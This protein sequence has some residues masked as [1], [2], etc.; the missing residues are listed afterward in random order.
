MHPWSRPTPRPDFAA[1]SAKALKDFRAA[2]AG[3]TAA[4][5]GAFKGREIWNMSW[6]KGKHKRKLA[7][8]M[9]R[10]KCVWCERLRD[11]S[12]E[13][14]VEHF[15]PKSSVAEWRGSPDIFSDVPPAQTI[16]SEH[17]YW[18]L[19][20]DWNNYSLACKT[21]N[22]TWK[23]SLFPVRLPRKTCVEG[24]ETEEE[25]LLIDPASAFRSGE[26]FRWDWSS[27][28]VQPLSEQAEATIITCGLNREELRD[29]REKVAHDIVGVALAF[30]QE[31][32]RCGSRGSHE[33]RMLLRKLHE[34]G[35]ETEEFTSMARW[36]IEQE[37]DIPW[38][39]I[40]GYTKL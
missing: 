1:E 31:L 5:G 11:L 8:S 10:T 25:P 2:I 35:E 6:R 20:F 26:H 24:V 29:A 33:E 30:L 16:I 17:G 4:H 34:F 37:T 19:A 40:D 36:L 38:T 14:S 18:W 39:E 22:E 13:L 32:E 9:Q 21:C 28:I 15:R 27:G 3:S 23:R 12:R 7:E